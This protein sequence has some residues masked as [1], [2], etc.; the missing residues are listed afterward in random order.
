MTQAEKLHSM[1]LGQ[2]YLPPPLR[3]LETSPSDSVLCKMSQQVPLVRNRGQRFLYF[4]PLSLFLNYTYEVTPFAIMY[5]HC[6][7]SLYSY[8]TDAASSRH[9]YKNGT[10][11]GKMRDRDTHRVKARSIWRQRQALE[12][13]P[14]GSRSGSFGKIR[15][16]QGLPHDN[17]TRE[18]LESENSRRQ[19]SCFRSMPVA[20]RME[21]G[22]R[23]RQELLRPVPTSPPL[24]GI[25]Q[26]TEG[27]RNHPQAS[28]RLECTQAARVE[29]QSRRIHDN[30][31][32]LH[33]FIL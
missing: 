10:S 23:Q 15:S 27:R 25:L 5:R 31:G 22:N 8:G 12:R 11:S 6:T 16:R 30:G 3:L 13:G 21:R 19:R 4:G 24:L 17:R 26:G 1:Q 29:V 32:G 33:T 7:L 28:L 9:R 18:S 2:S 14:H 20:Y